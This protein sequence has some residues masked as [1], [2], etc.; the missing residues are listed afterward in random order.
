MSKFAE[1]NLYAGHNIDEIKKSLLCFLSFD[2]LKKKLCL[3][4]MYPLYL[5]SFE[6]HSHKSPVKYK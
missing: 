1:L 6:L 2:K 5:N 3:I 4:L